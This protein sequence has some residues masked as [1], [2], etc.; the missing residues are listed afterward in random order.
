VT[1]EGICYIVFVFNHLVNA[2]LISVVYP[3]LA[4]GYAAIH[5]PLPHKV[6]IHPFSLCIASSADTDFCCLLFQRFWKFITIY[7]CS[8]IALKFLFQISCFCVCS[9]GSDSYVFWSFGA[10]CNTN[11]CPINDIDVS[12]LVAPMH[13]IDANDDILVHLSFASLYSW[14]LHH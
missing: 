1:T 2:N 13:E 3:L 7:C 9:I 5:F 14:C 8:T 11:A 10:I 6:T 12:L 4:F